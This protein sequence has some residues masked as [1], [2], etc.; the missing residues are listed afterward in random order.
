MWTNLTYAKQFN[1]T[2]HEAVSGEVSE[3]SAF[4]IQFCCLI[5]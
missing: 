5:H 4:D 3:F 1:Y 2:T